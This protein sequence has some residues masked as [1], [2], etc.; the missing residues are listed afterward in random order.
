MSHQPRAM[1]GALMANPISIPNPTGGDVL[2]GQRS[3][4]RSVS[5]ARRFG[6]TAVAKV[7]KL[8]PARCPDR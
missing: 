6:L 4:N 3:G 1:Q 2:I 7:L 5:G 8:R